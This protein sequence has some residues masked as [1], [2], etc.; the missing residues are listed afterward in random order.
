[1]NIHDHLPWLLSAITVWMTLLA[2]NKH[3]SAWVVGLFGQVGWSI[4]IVD[5]SIWGLVPLNLTLWALYA[6][7]HLKWKS[8]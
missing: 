1:M 2:G 4:W 6:R 7:N 5:S 3:K 8:A